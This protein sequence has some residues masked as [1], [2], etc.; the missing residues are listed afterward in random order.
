MPA[1][2]GHTMTAPAEPVSVDRVVALL[3]TVWAES[4]D[5]AA[6]DRIRFEIAVA[7]IVGNIAQHA[8]TAHPLEFSLHVCVHPDRVEARFCDGGRAFTLDLDSASLPDELAE[9]GRGLA[10]ARAAVD[11]VDYRRDEGQ[12]CWRIVQRRR[13]A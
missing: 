13:P 7:E 4:P 9:S 8:A 6:E 11:K 3:E 12:N 5:V 10:L 2:E 1:E